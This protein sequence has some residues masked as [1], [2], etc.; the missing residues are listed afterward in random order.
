[1]VEVAPSVV[2]PYRLAGWSF[3]GVLAYEIAQQLLGQASQSLKDPTM[4]R[5][6][7]CSLAKLAQERGDVAAEQAA[8]KTAAQIP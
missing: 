4:L 5:R 7:W 3:G 8:W 2:G 6:V 1:M